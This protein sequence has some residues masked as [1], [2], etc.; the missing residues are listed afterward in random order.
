MKCKQP[1]LGFEIGLPIPFSKMMTKK[2]D[3]KRSGNYGIRYRVWREE[4][5]GWK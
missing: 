4:G 2:S 3:T 1:Y 5:I